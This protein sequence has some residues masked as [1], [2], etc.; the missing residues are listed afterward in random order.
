MRADSAKRLP[1]LDR[2]LLRSHLG[3]TLA[4][5]AVAL[6]IGGWALRA[7]L[8]DQATAQVEIAAINTLRQLDDN[9]REL[10]VVA[11]LLGERPT[12]TR[13]LR[14]KRLKEAEVFL[15]TYARS[16]RLHHVR[17]EQGGVVL[18]ETGTPPP[19]PGSEGLQF[20]ATDDTPWRVVDGQFDDLPG[21]RLHL[22]ECQRHRA[23]QRPGDWY[24]SWPQMS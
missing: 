14:Q 11:Q 9:R 3:L 6:L 1:T 17:I 7:A 23:D 19:Q 21:A 22:P 18:V 16:A 2:L 13:L 20:S 8:F 24:R 15:D 5:V 12:L 4:L 10:T